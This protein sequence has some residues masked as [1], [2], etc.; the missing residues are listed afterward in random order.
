[1]SFV[2]GEIGM[3]SID[4]EVY[5]SDPVPGGSLSSTGARAILRSPAHFL[6]N[7]TKAAKEPTDEMLFG[8]VAHRL[9]LGA[10]EKIEI[11]DADNYKTKAAQEAKALALATGK[12]P[13]LPKAYAIAERMAAVV[14]SHPIAGKL[15]QGGEPEMTMVWAR[16]GIMCRAMADYVTDDGI[17]D[18]K[19]TTDVDLH[20]IRRAFWRYNYHQQDAFY[21]DGFQF[22]TGVA[23]PTFKFIFQEKTA[24]YVVR[25]V[26]LDSASVTEGR[27]LN[28]R[29]IEIYRD[30]E[31]LEEWPGHEDEAVISLSAHA[32]ESDDEGDE[33][34]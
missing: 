18:Y 6:H 26:S 24:P 8:T 10:G 12:T 28:E 25:V 27:L 31:A 2:A 1:M 30:C 22:T 17:V 16:N 32:N 5:H 3:Y 15:V 4:A 19:T 20:A 21:R 13:V 23:R 11:I 14:H 33:T 29:A 7:R 34:E 9:V